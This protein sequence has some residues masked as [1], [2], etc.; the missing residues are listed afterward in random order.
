MNREV[1]SLKRIRKLIFAAVMT[2]ALSVCGFAFCGD[3]FAVSASD[4]FTV[5]TKTVI[6]PL[7]QGEFEPRSSSSKGGLRAF[8]AE[9]DIPKFTSPEEAGEYMRS[10]MVRRA[11]TVKLILPV[12]LRSDTEESYDDQVKRIFDEY[13]AVIMKTAMR[14]TGKPEEGDYIRW[15]YARHSVSGENFTQNSL[16]CWNMTMSYEIS[17]LST[18]SEE[19]K[20]RVAA[21]AAIENLALEGRSDKDK[22][23][24]IYDRVCRSASYDYTAYRSDDPRAHTA[25][26]CIIRNR[27]VCQGYAL[28]L[29]RMLLEAGIDNRMYGGFRNEVQ[30]GTAET[31]GHIWNVIRIGKS[32]YMADATWDSAGAG[33]AN[34]TDFFLKGTKA[35]NKDGHAKYM[36]N[37]YDPLAGYPLSDV[38]FIHNWNTA[39]V[40]KAG[41]SSDGLSRSTCRDCGVSGRETVITRLKPPTLSRQTFVY[42]GSVQRPKVLMSALPDGAGYKVSWTGGRN[43]GRHTATITLTGAFYSGSKTLTYTIKPKGTSV[44]RLRSGTRSI[45][46][47][48]KKRTAGMAV[49]PINGY[50][51]RYSR[52]SSMSRARIVSIRGCSK[53]T[54][55]LTGLRP[56][57]KYYIQVRT[58]KTAGGVKYYSSW[59]AAKSIKT[60]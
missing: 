6:N 40:T 19:A 23:R 4:T 15:Q 56:R 20:V 3:C 2:A 43:V 5:Q 1:A 22:A 13:D 35:Y 50:Q 41:F 7:Y 60:K 42:N 21:A 10:M 25:Y 45:T 24:L 18:A 44:S 16:D 47:K 57:K 17:Y 32:Y 34:S 54:K 58:W 9:A 51:V 30:N 29:Y 36:N 31:F 8:G 14:H 59:S 27:C 33:I 53:N 48:W 55:K 38:C 11:A 49:T 12:T 52:S 39:V 46:V 37:I 28:L 26:S